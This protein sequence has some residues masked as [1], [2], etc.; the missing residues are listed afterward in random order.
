M[1]GKVQTALAPTREHR[2]RGFTTVHNF[3]FLLGLLFPKLHFLAFSDFYHFVD[4][5]S[6]FYAEV[7]QN[8]QENT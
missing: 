8:I 4:L 6:L 5:A 3:L 1:H 2:F 7:F